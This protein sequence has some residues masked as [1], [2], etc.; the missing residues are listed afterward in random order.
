M[1]QGAPHLA[2]FS[3]DVGYHHTQPQDLTLK[4]THRELDGCPTFAKAYVGRKRRGEAPPQLFIREY[5]KFV[6][7]QPFH[8]TWRRIPTTT[9]VA[10][11]LALLLTQAA[12]S[13]CD[14]QCLQRQQRRHAA[15]THCHAMQQPADGVAAQTCTPTA[16]SFCATDLLANNQEKTLVQSTI[17]VD[18]SP[19]GALTVPNTPSH[20]PVPTHLRSTIGDPP[21]LTPLRV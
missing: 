1:K 10:L 14:A 9:I 3:R 13:V 4:Q 7:T 12:S 15:M 2:R 18:A 19:V 5:P 17:H 21:L 8:S 6:V 16:N 11:L 20:T